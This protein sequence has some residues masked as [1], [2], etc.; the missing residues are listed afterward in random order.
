M[1]SSLSPLLCPRRRPPPTRLTAR[2]YARSLPLSHEPFITRVA[3]S[4]R[5]RPADPAD[6]CSAQ[7]R[8][9]RLGD[10]GIDTR[11]AVAP[12]LL[13]AAIDRSVQGN[14]YGQQQPLEEADAKGLSAAPNR[15]HPVAELPACVPAQAPPG[16]SA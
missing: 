5:D 3:Y 14:D 15:S 11:S 16:A 9:R 4:K 8:R 7:L 12:S 6:R 1:L 13:P 10:V 2:L